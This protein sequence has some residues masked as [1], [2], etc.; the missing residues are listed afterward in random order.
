MN[1]NAM[2]QA[3]LLAIL[4]AVAL[5][6]CKKREEVAVTPPPVASEPAPLPPVTPPPAATPAVSVATVDLGNAVGPDFRVTTPAT[7]FA[8]KDTIHASV[9]TNT[10]DATAS[11]PGKLAVKWTH[12]DSNQVV[13]EESRDVTFAGS[14]VTSFQISKP[15]GWPTGKYRVEVMLDGNTVQTREFEVR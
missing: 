9:A 10:G 14:G 13:H 2:S 8:A 11:V 15:D 12:L 6:G 7:T 4:G 3:L 5:A 1:R